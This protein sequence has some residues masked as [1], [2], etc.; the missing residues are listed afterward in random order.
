MGRGE[1]KWRMQKTVCS[2][3]DSVSEIWPG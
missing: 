1:M 3:N 2:F